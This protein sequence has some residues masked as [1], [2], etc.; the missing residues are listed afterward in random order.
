MQ[1]TPI[2]FEFCFCSGGQANG[3]CLKP[4][5]DSILRGHALRHISGLVPQIQHNAVS[6]TFVELVGMDIS[7]EGFQTGLFVLLQKRR[8]RETD[9]DGI[10][11]DRLHGR[12]ELAGLSAVALIHKHHNI[13]LCGKILGQCVFQILRCIFRN[14]FLSCRCRAFRIYVPESTEDGHRKRS[15]VQADLFHS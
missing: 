14:L 4:C 12:V 8:A 3:F 13:T 9:K 1:V 2:C 11:K 7:A 5:V 10:G 15:G 6:N